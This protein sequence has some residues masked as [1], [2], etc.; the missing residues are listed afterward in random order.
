MK[1]VWTKEKCQ[2]AALE[3]KYKK[4]FCVKFS[5]AYAASYRNGWID[6]ICVHMVS[7]DKPSGYWT[8]EKC[9]D[10]TFGCENREQF[11]KKCRSAYNSACK[12]NW[13]DEIC[14]HMT[15]EEHVDKN[16]WTKEK[17]QEV[18]LECS[19][20]SEFCKKYRGAY[21][22]SLN[23][24]WLNEICSHMQ[25]CGN[26]HN[27]L[28]YLIEFGDN[29]VYVGLTY[30]YS[31]RYVDHLTTDVSSSVF[32]YSK[33]TGLIPTCKKLT[34]YINIVNAIELEI[35]YIQYYKYL[36]YNV[37]NKTNGGEYGGGYLKFDYDTCKNE[38]EKYTKYDF[39]K[40]K[41]WAYEKSKKEGW[42]SDFIFKQ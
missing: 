3:C 27:R 38:A 39:R 6:E 10:A 19:F 16:Y 25:I 41:R 12:N 30:N 34:E 5:G 11:R 37:I 40:Y 35:Y 15:Y 17:C 24:G 22:K 2:Q 4:E 33:K 36:G 21:D 32:K 7:I 18:A 42:L 8:K 20:R 9:Q 28:V 13:L 14:S 31:K 29:S 1:N 26:L 23:N